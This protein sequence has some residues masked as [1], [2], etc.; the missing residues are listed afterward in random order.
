MVGWNKKTDGAK[1]SELFQMKRN[2]GGLDYNRREKEYIEASRL[3]HFPFTPFK[4][5]QQ[6]YK[7]K[8]NKVSVDNK[9]KGRR[10][11]SSGKIFLFF[12]LI[13]DIVTFL[14]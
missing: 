1:L 9:L 14:I 12:I 4:N 5:F 6:I 10:K 2:R 8:A 3:K 7:T 13:Y 11:S